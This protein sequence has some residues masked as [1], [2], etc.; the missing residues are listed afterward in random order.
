MIRSMSVS[1]AMVVLAALGILSVLFDGGVRTF[2]DFGT[3][4][5]YQQDQKFVAL[6]TSVGGMTHELQKERGASA[7]YLA[8]GGTAFVD[9]LP[10][11]RGLSDA[12]I[13]VFQEAIA[14][15]QSGGAKTPELQELVDGV[16]GQLADLAEL[17]ARVDAQSIELLDAVGTITHLNRSAIALL[18][19]IGKTITQ[20]ESARAV[21][22]HAIFMTAK[23]VAGLERAAGAA[24]FARAA[25]D[26]V[27]PPPVLA[28]FNS[29]ID[30]QGVLFSIYEQLAT[31]E[32]AQRL[33][34]LREDPA[35][36]EVER[37]RAVARSGDATAIAAVGS[38]QWFAKITAVIDLIKQAEDAGVDE[39]SG[40]MN[41]AIDSGWRG[42]V[43]GVAELLAVLVVL[44]FLS[45]AL[46]SMTNRWLRT[47]A[48]RVEAL[49]EGEVDEEVQQAPQ[50][51]LAKI[52]H[53]LEKFRASEAGAREE[54]ETQAQLEKSSAAGIKRITN[55]VEQGQFSQRLRLRDLQG[56]SQ[57]LGEGINLILDATD[58]VVTEQR[59]RDNAVLEAQRREAEAQ[60]QTIAELQAVVRACSSGDFSKSMP[61]DRLDG[62]W[63]DVAEGINQI[64][65]MTD[66]ALADFRRI[67]LAI[68][69][70]DLD[71]RMTADLRGTFA[72]IGQATNTS[73]DQIREALANVDS[74]ARSIGETAGQMRTGAADLARRS[75]EQATTVTESS[76]ATEELASTVVENAKRL[77]ECLDLMK[78]LEVKMTKGQSV[79]EEAVTSMS[80]IEEAS[81][82]MGK[83]VATIDEIAFQTNLLALN[84]S[85]EAARAGEAGKGFAVVAQEVR[86]LASRCADASKQIGGLINESVSGVKQG[87]EHVR[88]S[89]EVIREMEK[90]IASVVSAI[91][92]VNSAGQEQTRGVGVLNEA[93]SRLERMA[94]SNVS[95]ARNN[96]GLVDD[97]S[98]LEHRL[99]AA[100]SAVMK[101]T[102]DNAKIVSAA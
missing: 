64:A 54:R 1:L 77:S 98:D 22:R 95:L 91:E 3:Y 69:D 19:E 53:A 67:M 47:T 94:Q 21:Q 80:E 96:S 36:R 73:L 101:S 46:V 76:A 93:I 55:A 39:I 5:S 51:D 68:A 86:A 44:T 61:L 9:A 33:V 27:F 18:P 37:L 32:M 34:D 83:I 30:E 79:A 4:Q 49:A 12:R 10:K 81:S 75:D 20:T 38:E 42:L 17:R 7:G 41:D 102:S 23:D 84:A 89:G 40:F 85:V 31:A 65:S 57:I 56:A 90:T 100:V 62:V 97:L 28:R 48:Q 82:E 45:A 92:G 43:I 50:S 74:G 87:A 99:A 13:A 78:A 52:T 66:A 88:Q 11:Q 71:Q 26:G 6:A 25:E 15:L 2:R 58:R 14:E 29:L 35:T 24:G 60:E 72:E 59:E 16:Q 63:R 8:S 70:G